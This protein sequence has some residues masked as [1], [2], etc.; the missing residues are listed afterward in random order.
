MIKKAVVM[1]VWAFALLVLGSGC[2]HFLQPEALSPTPG[3]DKT[4]ANVE[5]NNQP[6][7]VHLAVNS[8]PNRISG[9]SSFSEE[10]RY[11]KK[12]YF[13]Y[14]A[15]H[16]KLD[17]YYFD[18]PVVY[19]DK[20][21]NWINYFLTRGRGF[22]ERYSERAGRYAPIMGKILKDYGLPS[23]LIF[24]AMAE[25]GFQNH[26]KSWAKA[27]GPW[28]FMPFTARR[29]G[30]IVDWSLDERRDPIKSTIAAARYL[31]KLYNEFGSWELA[32]AAY[33]AGEG[34]VNRAIAKYETE[35]FWDMSKGRYLKRETKEYVPKIMALAIIGKNLQAFGFQNLNFHEPMDFDE[36]EVPPMAD[37]NLL[38]EAIGVDVDVIKYLNPEILRWYVP[39][40][41]GNYQLRVPVGSRTQ[42]NNCCV[43][44]SSKLMATAFQTYKVTGRS[45]NIKEVA[46]KQKVG[47]GVLAHINNLSLGQ[48]LPVGTVLNLPFR[49]DQSRKDS[50]YSDLYE[51]PRRKIASRKQFKQHLINAKKNGKKITNPTEYYVVQKGDTLWHVSRKSGV[52]LDTLIASNLELLQDRPIRA[53]DRLI[54]R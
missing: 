14:G 32:A 4:V 48:Q 21:Q 47:P 3:D 7:S 35:S 28:Q 50:M 36:I 8:D 38:S 17:N 27:V 53:G 19:N 25:S 34:K 46:S 43:K 22:F 33:N 9:S 51:K 37:L 40:E 2:G 49:L 52:A 15:E 24:L 44:D 20:V 6:S 1:N 31:T 10:H 5:K 26:A 54:L 16:L 41:L 29:Y 23:D 39:H 30:L 42:W 45:M 11:D 12:V 18:F 13:L